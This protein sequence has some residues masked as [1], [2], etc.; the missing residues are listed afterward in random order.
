MSY[1]DFK[2]IDK[3]INDLNLM[4]EESHNLFAHVSPVKPSQR[5]IETLEE[6]LE[7]ATNIRY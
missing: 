5:L 2:T 6:T 7:L 3:A 1:S 4:I